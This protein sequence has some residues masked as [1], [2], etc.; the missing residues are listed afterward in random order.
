MD[1]ADVVGQ[2]QQGL[3]RVLDVERR[4]RGI[5]LEHVRD[6]RQ[7]TDHV[8]RMRADVAQVVGVA[9]DRL[10]AEVVLLVAGLVARHARAVVGVALDEVDHLGLAGGRLEDLAFRELARGRVGEALARVDPLGAIGPDRGLLQR[11]PA[12]QRADL[13]RGMAAGDQAVGDRAHRV[14]AVG[15][16]GERARAKGHG[17]DADEV[18]QAA[19]S[20]HHWTL[21]SSSDAAIGSCAFDDATVVLASRLARKTGGLD[22]RCDADAPSP[23][24]CA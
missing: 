16:P 4:G 11:Q 8:E 2:Q 15:A 7:G 24:S 12:K 18:F 17:D 3:A 14:V 23:S 21:R 22:W 10:V 19:H 20:L 6:G 9:L 13:L 1:V 5:A